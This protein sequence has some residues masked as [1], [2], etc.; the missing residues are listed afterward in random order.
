MRVALAIGSNLGDRERHLRLAVQ[1][2]RPHIDHLRVSSVH[3]TP[4]VGDGPAQPSYL[5]GAVVGETNLSVRQLLSVLLTVEQAY[6]RS[7][8]YTN[9]PRT[10]DL[11]LILY[12]DAIVDQPGLE[13]PHPRFRERGFVLMPL[14]EIASDW[15]DPITGR[16]VEELLR[17]LVV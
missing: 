5:N 3:E 10:L 17:V 16:T 14:A 1:A 6:G 13:V 4:Y 2:L 8:P 7:R 11:D 9:G 15:R 12:G